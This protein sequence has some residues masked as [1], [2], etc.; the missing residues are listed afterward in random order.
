MGTAAQHWYNEGENNAGQDSHVK[1][2]KYNL[3]QL[4]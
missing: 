3:D 2:G 4:R 1:E